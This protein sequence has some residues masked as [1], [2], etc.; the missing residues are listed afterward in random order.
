MNQ[1]LIKLNK[2]SREDCSKNTL[3]KKENSIQK[4][5]LA[6]FNSKYSDNQV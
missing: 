1:S 6:S 4:L 5:D 2:I 3:I